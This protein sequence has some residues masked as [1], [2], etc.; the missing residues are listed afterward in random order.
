MI[1]AIC[2]PTG[3]GKTTLAFRL[4]EEFNGEIIN[5]DSMQVYRGLDIGT[6]KEKKGHHLIDIV[7][8]DEDYTVYNY[9]IDC[10]QKIKE[11]LENKKIPILV[12]GTGLYLKAVLYDYKFN[13]EDIK[14]DYISET[15][16]E[17]Y[18][19]LLKI[20]PDTSVHINN[21]KRIIR[22]LNYFDNNSKPLSKNKKGDKL[23]YDTL[24]VGLTMDREDLYER[25]NLR[26]DKMFELGL[27]DEVK[28]FYDLGIKSKALATGI[29]Y[30]ELYKYF[31]N[32]ITLD[33]AK[34]LIKKNTRK[35]AKKQ[36]TFYNNK[37]DV[38][39]FVNNKEVM[40]YIKKA[41]N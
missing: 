3:V 12:G 15:N 18:N 9:Q 41:I 29:G 10:R 11:V 7:D 1:I 25:L 13:K 16:Q 5:Y 38:N 30:K 32:D 31:D 34:E 17:L 39:W 6:A 4:K 35:Y 20:D 24:F 14:K 19:M 27:I 8:V 22:S 33:E 2:G 28:H 40:E 21:R 37:F 36:Y 26:V 23:L